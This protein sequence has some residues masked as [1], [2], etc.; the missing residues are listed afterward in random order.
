ML[1]MEKKSSTKKNPNLTLVNPKFILKSLADLSSLKSEILEEL[2][3][4]G[5]IDDPEFI[6]HICRLVEY[7]S[8]LLK[9]EQK[10]SLVIDIVK[11]LLPV[12]NNDKSIA[13]MKKLIK[14]LCNHQLVKPPSTLKKAKSSSFFCHKAK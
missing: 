9:G 4:I 5:A 8:C 2:R 1:D 3:E 12:L 13:D 10:E 11:E 14:L 7:S 6:L